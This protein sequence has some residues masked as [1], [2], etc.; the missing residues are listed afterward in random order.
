L[1]AAAGEGQVTASELSVQLLF[2]FVA[3]RLTNHPQH[4]DI[5]SRIVR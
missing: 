5:A 3:G 1:C 2:D 4:V